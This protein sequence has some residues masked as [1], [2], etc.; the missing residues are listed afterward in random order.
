MS[1]NKN[2]AQIPNDWTGS[3]GQVG[4]WN[5]VFFDYTVEHTPGVPSIRIDP[6]KAGAST[7]ST[8]RQNDFRE[9]EAKWFSCKAGDH[10]I[11]KVW[12]KMDA[13]TVKGGSGGHLGIDLYGGGNCVWVCWGPDWEPNPG[14]TQNTTGNDGAQT[15][16]WG[17]DWTL[18]TIDFIVPTGTFNY[19][20]NTKT[21]VPAAAI[22]SFVPWIQVWSSDKGATDPSSGYFTDTELYINPV[23]PEEPPAPSSYNLTLDSQP[24][25]ST[26]PA[27][28][29][30]NHQEGTEVSITANPVQGYRF[31]SWNFNGTTLT[32][33]PYTFTMPSE[34]VSAT[35]VF[36]ATTPPPAK[37]AAARTIG[38]FGLPT[39]VLHQ[40]WKLRERYIRPEVHKKLHPL[41]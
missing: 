15:V 18:R 20:P 28:G 27:T 33:N 24:G 35:A 39:A 21:S 19:N 41:V 3:W 1:Q 26:N 40:L 36:E 10:I 9:C 32:N 6:W 4:F 25:G 7:G 11:F 37:T 13:G 23:Y 34:D 30:Y 22:D 5:N 16:N 14:G 12:V 38:P 31:V 29:T 2:L 17:S 8:G